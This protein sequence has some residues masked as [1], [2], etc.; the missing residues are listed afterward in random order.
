MKRQENIARKER[1]HEER[2]KALVER[3]KGGG[4]KKAK[5]SKTDILLLKEVYDQYDIDR[6][7]SVSV[8]E[9]QAALKMTA[10]ADST[11]AMLTELDKNGDGTVAFSELLKV[12][13]SV[14]CPHEA[15][16]RTLEL[17]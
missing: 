15:H 6:S 8:A 14:P 16:V 7:G 9:M 11:E 1:E 13:R 2:A 12:A 5:Y 17:A 4:A 3:K 10:L